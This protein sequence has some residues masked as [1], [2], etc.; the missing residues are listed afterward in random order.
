MKI[1]PRQLEKMAK[2]M[3]M[4]MDTIPAEEVI[5]RT[6]EKD[7]VLRNPQVSKV[8]MMGQETYQITGELEEKSRSEFTEDDVDMVMSQTGASRE[9]AESALKDTHGDLAE[10]ILRIKS[11]KGG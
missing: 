7:L 11:S 5:I 6:A 3:G 8:N 2:R 10:S 1:N 9:D 4:Q